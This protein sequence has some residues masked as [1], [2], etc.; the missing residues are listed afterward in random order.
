MSG[1]F[2]NVLENSINT[3]L[4]TNLKESIE[5]AGIK[6]PASKCLW[7]Y[8]KIIRDNLVTKT[9]NGINIRGGD[10]INITT[11]SDGDV[12]TYNINTI[13]DTFDN[14]RPNY[15][16]ENTKWG[17]EVTVKDL[18]DDLFD[19][20]LPAVRGVHAGDITLT[21]QNGN[22]K[23]EWYNTLFNIRGNKTGLLANSRYIRLYLTSQPEPIYIH[24]TNL[25]ED[26]TNGYNVVDSDTITFDFDNDKGLLSA[27]INV[28]NSEQLKELGI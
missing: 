1:L 18:F 7:Q 20:I 28:I 14:N 5:S 8:P 10:V 25:V 12:L 4:Q 17:K 11:E 26:L 23:K 24:I 9:V 6:I 3:G 22:D 2:D 13:F 21:D 16:W 27:Y 15:A 19:N